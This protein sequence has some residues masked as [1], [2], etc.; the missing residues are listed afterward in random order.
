MNAM[1]YSPSI[2]LIAQWWPRRE[3]GR[4]LGILGIFVGLAMLIMWLI[5]GW[6]AGPFG[7]RA[8]F[9]SCLATAA[10]LAGIAFAA[11]TNLPLGMA[12]MMLG[13]FTLTRASTTA[14]GIDLAGRR[15]SGIASA[16]LDAPA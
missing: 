11:P 16:L 9:R 7:W 3:R 5:T 13:G 8:A 10:V 14:L 12:L 4:A 15:I 1:Y 6:V 2:R